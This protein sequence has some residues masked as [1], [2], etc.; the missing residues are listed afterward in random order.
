MLIIDSFRKP[1]GWLSNFSKAEITFDGITYPT[2]EHAFQA[3]KTDNI[4]D[5]VKIAAIGNPVVVK[6]MGK[7]VKMREDWN[8]IRL[9]VMRMLVDL[10]FQDET[11]SEKLIETGDAMLVE[12]NHWHDNYWGA[13][14][15]ERC[16]SKERD[17]YLGMILMEKREQLK[18]IV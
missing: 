1:Y 18:Q 2:L 5:K 17:N 10:K 8:V 9:D 7:K 4:E 12:G 13:C 15:C 11:L 6:R 16:S 14:S 3:A